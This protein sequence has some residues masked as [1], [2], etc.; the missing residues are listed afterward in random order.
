MAEFDAW[1]EYYD[2][3]HQGLPGEAEFY[4]GQA[5]RIGGRTL[6]LGCGTGRIAIPM[7]M[8]GVEVTGLD[9]SEAMLAIC[10]EKLSAVGPL[11]GSLQLV[12][13]DM[14]S[15]EL[16]QQFDFIAMPYRT[17]MHVHGVEQQR[18]CLRC[19]HEHLADD[20]VCVLNTWSPSASVI[21][22]H[23]VEREFERVD[24]YELD[25]TENHLQHYHRAIY[26]EERQRIVEEHLID[27]VREDGQVVNSVTLPLVRVWTYPRE[28]QHLITLCGFRTEAVFGDFECNPRTAATSEQIIV[29]RKMT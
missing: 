20:G 18:A 24:E 15:F 4:V 27:E 22:A 21:A 29:L 2:I 23:S 25:D 16:G 9:R 19:I 28:L 14:T 6:E 11:S 8:S 5:V 7:A 17:F 1:A 10:R 3:I 13:A 12:N 26:D